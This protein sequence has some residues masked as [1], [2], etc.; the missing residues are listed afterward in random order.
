[1]GGAQHPRPSPG[2]R[3]TRCPFSYSLPYVNT[4]FPCGCAEN[5]AGNRKLKTVPDLINSMSFACCV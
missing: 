5:A 2:H 4:L 3:V 1:M